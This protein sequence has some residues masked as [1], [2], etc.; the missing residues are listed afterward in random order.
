M[1]HRLPTF[2][3]SSPINLGAF[4]VD[5]ARSTLVVLLLFDP[6]L[7]ERGQGGQD[8]A[9]NPHRVFAF[10]RGDDLDG[11]RVRG[12]GLHLLLN[13]FRNT[14]VHGGASRHHHVSVQVLTDVHIA[15]HDG[16][17]GQLVDA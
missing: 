10:W 13:S 6:H 9:T 7:L 14:L 17:E 3:T 12:Q 8:G 1:A 16:R 5:N 11:H 2:T 15:L 4:S